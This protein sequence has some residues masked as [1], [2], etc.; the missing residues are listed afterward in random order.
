[1]KLEQKKQVVEEFK[2]EVE[3]SGSLILTSYQGLNVAGITE[4]RRKLKEV[5]SRMLVIKNRLALRS[6]EGLGD[7]Y[8]ELKE[9]F[10]GPVA[11]IVGDEDPSAAVKIFKKYADDNE[12]MDLKA[13]VI[14]GNYYERDK[15]IKLASL[16]SREALLG[17]VAGMMNAPIQGLYNVLGGVIKSFMYALNDLKS[18]MESGEIKAPAEQQKEKETE[19]EAAREKALSEEKEPEEETASD[20]AEEQETSSEEVADNKEE[21]AEEKAEETVEDAADKEVKDEQQ[22]ENKEDKKEQED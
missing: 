3:A 18:K 6:I 22:E 2:K 7:E 8:N 16:P 19:Q 13:A 12:L 1:M 20:K 10:K 9:Y 15:V 4:L 5:N 17:Q 11:V 14:S 21:P